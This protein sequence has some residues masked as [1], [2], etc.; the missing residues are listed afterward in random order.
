MN[1]EYKALLYTY[2]GHP[3]I[4]ADTRLPTGICE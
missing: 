1:R 3:L 4:F 2:H